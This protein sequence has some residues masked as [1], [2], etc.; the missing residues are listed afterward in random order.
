VVCAIVCVCPAGGSITIA[1][2]DGGT[3]G[4]VRIKASTAAAAVPVLE[5]STA[6]A[7][8][9]TLSTFAGGAFSLTVGAAL[10][11]N[12]G[13]DLTF[14]AGTSANLT[15]VG[16]HE[17]S[18]AGPVSLTSVVDAGTFAASTSLLLATSDDGAAA[19]A[20][21]A[22]SIVTGCVATPARRFAATASV[23]REGCCVWAGHPSAW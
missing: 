7:T 11:L 1:P 5:V 15:A 17:V 8:V 9:S 2:G 18:A 21:G 22:V 10:T 14:D 3:A 6:G 19:G 4:V 23:S 20:S 13:V 16:N 12:A